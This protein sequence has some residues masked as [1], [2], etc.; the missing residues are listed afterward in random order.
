MKKINVAVIFG[1]KSVEHEVSVESAR[2]VC[3]IISRDPA[4]RLLPVYIDKT[5]RWSAKDMNFFGG[6]KKAGREMTYNASKNAFY[7]GGKRLAIDAAFSLI[8]GNTGE[9]GKLQGLLELAGIPYVGCDVLASA[10]AMDKK[11]S[12]TAAELAG[13]PVLK[14]AVVT[15]KTF[16]KKFRA[17]SAA[18]AKMGYPV[19]VKPVSL[20]SSV[21]VV[22]VKKPGEL[23]RAVAYALKFDR[24][25]MI[26][27]GVDRAREIVCG[28]LGDWE[29]AKASLCG[30]V[31][32][33]G[34]HEFYDYEAKYVDN[35]G[36]RL[37]IPAPLSKAVSEKIREYASKIFMAVKGY[38]L[39][40]V[41]FF[42]NPENEKEVYFCEINTIPGFTS[43]S[44][45]PR[46]WEKTG[47]KPGKLVAELI[48][49]ALKR[50]V[51]K[52][53]LRTERG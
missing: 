41:D 22:K 51:F 30:E 27:K 6:K 19:F 13:L 20:G 31:K 16:R 11:L 38:G 44:L 43:H 33:R 32:P 7:S 45:Y 29:N 48:N 15:A 23:K 3:A 50:R 26:E 2:S 36:M 10:L 53:G 14:D 34:K 8:H 52:N 5:G 49:L 46:L 24:E 4:Y 35:D 40:R 17:V 47:V 42:I 9:D 39:S 1:G 18:A 21:G 37:L 28:V 12:K 25:V